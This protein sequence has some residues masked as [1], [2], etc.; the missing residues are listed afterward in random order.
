MTEQAPTMKRLF[1]VLLA[2]SQGLGYL[3]TGLW[4][5][6]HMRSF[7]RVTGP[8][9]DEWLVNTVGALVAVVG[10]VLF[11]AGVRRRVTAE[12]AALAAGAA[13]ALSAVDV[14]YVLRR[15]ISPVY[16]LDAV[17]E[18]GLIAGWIAGAR[19]RRPRRVPSPSAPSS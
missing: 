19:A 14:H 9:T 6:F 12:V 4:P 5:L 3:A 15:R 18:A 11:L 17:L 2:V 8:K 1:V 16:L 13:A 7:Q 10:A